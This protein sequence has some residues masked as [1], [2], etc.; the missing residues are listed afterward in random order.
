MAIFDYNPSAITPFPYWK[1]NKVLPAVYDDSVSQYEMLCRLLSVVN[2]I[3]ESTNSTGEQVEALTQLVQQLIDGGFPEGLVEYVNDIVEAAMA[4]DVAAINN[5]INA[6]REDIESAQS[7]IDTINDNGWVTTNRLADGSVTPAKMANK[8]IVIFGDSW[9]DP[10]VDAV[11][12]PEAIQRYFGNAEIHN[13]SLNGCHTSNGSF[14]R[15]YNAFINDTSYDKSTITH[16][17]LV[18]GVNDFYTYPITK[19]AAAESLSMFVQAVTANG[20]L[21]SN[22]PIHWFINHAYGKY[23]YDMID[24]ISYWHWVIASGDVTNLI[25]PHETWSWFNRAEYNQTNFF[26]LLS[27]VQYFHFAENIYKCLTGGEPTKF[28]TYRGSYQ[29]VTFIMDVHED[30][31]EVTAEWPYSSSIISHYAVEPSPA[32]MPFKFGMRNL[33]HADGGFIKMAISSS[34]ATNIN[35]IAFVSTADSSNLSGNTNMFTVKLYPTF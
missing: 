1:W 33:P 27:G 29:D 7:Q 30:C 2:N 32:I 26:H 22:V 8:V 19:E 24:Q 14:V 10:N 17:I 20:Q 31:V 3:I 28:V 23:A 13:Y 35:R 6:L 21:P 18:Y 12:F 25:I 5:T 4:D 11:R 16:C 34:D 15:M 9:S